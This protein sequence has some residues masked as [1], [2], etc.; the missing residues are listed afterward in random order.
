MNTDLHDRSVG[1][2]TKELSRDVSELVRKELMLA[3]AEMATKA[4]RQPP[5][6]LELVAAADPLVERRVHRHRQIRRDRALADRARHARVVDREHE[7][8]RHDLLVGA[9][10]RDDGLRRRRP[11]AS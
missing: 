10:V 1:E 3:K 4:Q 6:V 8:A 11:R 7:D 2:L 9:D 5:E